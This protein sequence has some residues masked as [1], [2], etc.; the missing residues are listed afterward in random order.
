M[1][2]PYLPDTV[3]RTA[4]DPVRKL[5]ISDRIF[6]TMS[7]AIEHGIEPVNMAVGAMAGIAVLLNKA[8]EN[9]L[10]DNLRV[11]HWQELSNMGI[12]KILMWIWG[13]ECSKDHRRLIECVQ[14]AKKHLAELPGT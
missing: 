11:K 4:R 14:Q 2:N 13:T 12:E 5:G 6:G 3:E 10:P 7:L 8:D 1:T 9:N